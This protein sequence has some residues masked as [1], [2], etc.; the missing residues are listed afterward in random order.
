MRPIASAALLFA[1]AIFASPAIA[2]PETVVANVNGQ[3]ITEA[4]LGFAEAEIGSELAGVPAESRRRVLVEYLIEAHLMADAAEKAKLAD[5]KDFAGRMNYYRMRA[6]RDAFFEKQIRDSVPDTEAKALYD[7]RVKSLPAQEEIRA[8]HILVKT[9]DEAKK[10]AAELAAGADFAE[11]ATKYSQ[12]RGGQGGGD[13]GYF[14]RGQMVKSFEDAAFSLEKG[15]LS[16]PIQTEFGWHIL[17]VEDKRDRQ[18]P[19][20]DEVKEQI[21]ASLIQSK[22]QS[23]VLDLR[24]NGKIEILDADLKKAVE[25][26]EKAATEAQPQSP[27]PADA[28]KK[29]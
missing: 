4:E 20:F 21:S 1:A 17:K 2:A 15:K 9:E 6:L 23:T 29:Q 13:L 28:A 8:R 19:S 27:Q 26:D 24:K 16:A 3:G 5:G 25:A 14:A 10:V 7:E 12:D 11:T 22:L 18:P